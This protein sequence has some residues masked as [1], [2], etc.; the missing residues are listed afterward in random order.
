MCLQLAKSYELNHST[1]HSQCTDM[2]ALY[3]CP[4]HSTN[5]KHTQQMH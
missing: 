2:N 5:V 4:P 1:Q 3:G